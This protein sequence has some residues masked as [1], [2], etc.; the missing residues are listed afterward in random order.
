MLQI[1]A[2]FT[3]RACTVPT[4]EGSPRPRGYGRA[5][6]GTNTGWTV[7]LIQPLIKKMKER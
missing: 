6:T 4:W 2:E 1:G 7:A 3:L 5:K